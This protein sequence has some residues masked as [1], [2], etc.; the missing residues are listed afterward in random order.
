MLDLGG[1]DVVQGLKNEVQYL[2]SS[3]PSFG[4]LRIN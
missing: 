2:R 1:R 3:S 4:R